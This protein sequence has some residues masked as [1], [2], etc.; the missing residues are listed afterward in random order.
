M[1][2]G[3]TKLELSITQRVVRGVSDVLMFLKVLDEDAKHGGLCLRW[4]INCRV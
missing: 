3:N 4:L 2:L 1:L